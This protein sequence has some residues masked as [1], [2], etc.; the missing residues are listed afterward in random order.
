MFKSNLN[1]VLSYFRQRIPNA[2]SEAFD[3]RIQSIMLIARG[4]RVFDNSALAFCSTAAN[5]TLPPI[6]FIKDF[7][8]KQ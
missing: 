2:A 7:F 4:F 3:S 6:S 5:L 1:E 8:G